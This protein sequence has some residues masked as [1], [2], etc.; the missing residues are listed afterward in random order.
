M[1]QH[2][3]FNYVLK[4]KAEFIYSL[5]PWYQEEKTMTVE[6][7]DAFLLPNGTDITF[8]V[9]PGAPF[10]RLC[11]SMPA[12]MSYLEIPPKNVVQL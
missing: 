2:A 11:V 10:R 4:G 12:Q 1:I 7:G 3:E 5:P 9:A 8:K 6:E